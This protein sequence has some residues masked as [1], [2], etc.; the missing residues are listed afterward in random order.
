M[1]WS[2]WPTRSVPSD[3]MMPRPEY[4]ECR[5]HGLEAPDV[6]VGLPESGGL[7]WTEQVKHWVLLL[8]LQR[9]YF[10]Y[11]VSCSLLASAAFLSTFADLL[12][13][14]SLDRRWEDI[15]E[16]NTWQ[17]ACWTVVG[18]ALCAEV[19][20]TA[21]VRPGGLK[22]ALSQDWWMAFDAAV[23]LMTAL[24]W[25]LMRLRKASRMREEA[26]EADLWLLT[27]RF[28]LQPCR[29]FV[30][31]KMAHKVQVMQNSHIDI[32]FDVLADACMGAQPD[33]STSVFPRIPA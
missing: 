29:V 21:V 3:D 4:A 12:S 18:L 7:H 9:P 15:L 10:V 16:G 11:C 1:A 30:A 25:M 26:E 31:A 32:N 2:S 33:C 19:V 24:A 5:W 22:A 27:L 23:V 6:E 17:S 28:A 20:S 14:R 13:D 8:R